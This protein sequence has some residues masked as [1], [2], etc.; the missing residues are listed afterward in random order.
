M[1]RPYL[2]RDEAPC[3]PDALGHTPFD[4][5]GPNAAYGFSS[6]LRNPGFNPAFR[7]C[8]KYKLDFGTCE[9]LPGY[10]HVPT[11]G[12]YTGAANYAA[13]CP[14]PGAL[15]IAVNA[16]VS[17]VAL[18]GTLVGMIFW[19]EAAA[20]PPFSAKGTFARRLY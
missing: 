3:L 12:N 11:S 14:A 1:F 2:P 8:G 20:G 10:T 6:A 9:P 15:P 16:A 17:G 5:G 4:Q 18:C 19:C 13:A 7:F